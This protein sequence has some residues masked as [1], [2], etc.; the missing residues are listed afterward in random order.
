MKKKWEKG[1]AGLLIGIAWT[2]IGYGV[3][4][5]STAPQHEPLLGW[6]FL[7]PLALPG[8]LLAFPLLPIVLIYPRIL[9]P[10]LFLGGPILFSLIGFAIGYIK[11]KKETLIH[12]KKPNNGVKRAG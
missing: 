8:L 5:L 11:D 12:K 7:I 6:P 3:S 2:A 9:I 1:L 10:L 4:S